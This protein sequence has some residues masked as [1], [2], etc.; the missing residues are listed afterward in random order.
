LEQT[1]LLAAFELILSSDS[2]TKG[3]TLKELGR[4]LDAGS[5]VKDGPSAAVLRA[6]AALVLLPYGEA[7]P[8][9]RAAL[10]TLFGLDD[11]DLLEFDFIGFV[12]TTALFDEAASERYLDRLAQIAT[13]ERFARS[14]P[15]YGSARSSSWIEATRQQR[16]SISTKSAR[17]AAPSD[18]TRRT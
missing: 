4:R 13:P 7:V 6:L 10:D 8:F 14:I 15:C 11:A 18:M 1:A 2:L 12:F 3:T 16:R 5:Q 17:C 9:M